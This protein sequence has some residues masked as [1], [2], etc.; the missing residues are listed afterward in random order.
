MTIGIISSS[1]QFLSLAYTLA[2]NNLQVC[3]YFRPGQDPYVNE[4]VKVLAARFQLVTGQQHEDVYNWVKQVN[5]AVVFV[6]GYPSLLDVSQFSMPAFNIHA[7]P[8]PSFRGPV[9]VFWQ[10]KM[11]MLRL[12]LSIHV[13]NERF[14]AGAVVW[15]KYIPDQ[16]HYNYS[17]VHQIFSQLVVEGVHY[18]LNA[19][20][21]GK[22][23]AP[24]P[25]D[26]ENAYHHRPAAKD[27]QI[28][29]KQ[30]SAREICNLIRACNPWNKGAATNMNGQQIKIMD[31]LQTG[32]ATKLPPGSV[33]LEDTRL[34][35]AAGDA[36]LIQVNML[37][38]E[39]MYVAAYQAAYY[40]IQKGLILQ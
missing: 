22:P 20:V 2:N 18:I 39:D 31:G 12:C 8:L 3:I 26:G 33:V 25:P 28:D 9:P 4:K 17:L 29:W 6:Y 27:V 10:L 40:G 13:L 38:L 35:V 32:I 30:M 11:G 5:P 1:D 7:G 24:I 19:L 23:P 15:N 36:Q 14:D 16:P 37:L 34:L 21:S